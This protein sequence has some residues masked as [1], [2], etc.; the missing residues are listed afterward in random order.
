MKGLCLIIWM[1]ITLILTFS[2]IGM[3]LFIGKHVSYDVGK[4]EIY[5]STWME[6]GMGLFNSVISEK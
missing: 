2:I 5:K 3:V 1:L 4:P 6:I